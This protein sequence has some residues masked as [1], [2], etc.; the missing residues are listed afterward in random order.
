MLLSEDFNNKVTVVLGSGSGGF[1]APSQFSVGANSLDVTVGDF[2]GDSRA[3]LA[4]ANGRQSANPEPNVASVSVLFG[5]GAGSFGPAASFTVDRYPGRIVAGDFNGDGRADLVTGNG[6]FNNISVLINTCGYTV[7]MPTL[8]F[9]A[10]LYSVGE[11]VGTVTVTVTRTGS[12]A[13]PASVKYATSDGTASSRSD[14]IASF[15]TLRFADGESAK[16]FKVFII[17]DLRSLENGESVNVTLS[18][19]IGATLGTT[20]AAVIGIFDNDTQITSAN[21]SDN[22]D[23]FVR[24][25]YLDFLNRQP[26]SA[27]IG[28]WT[29]QITEC[30]TLPQAERAACREVRR[31][32]VS[33]AFF[34]SIEFQETGYLV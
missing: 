25:H 11:G 6:N 17:D 27:G 4:V 24:Q 19:P 14:Y 2:N 21:P 16:A 12:T 18:G 31:I 13:G 32:N 9:G 20:T 8:Q 3:D 23:F 22:P 33:A 28:F 30:D 26:D 10:S 15:G 34:L 1:G 7:P 5:D 29:N